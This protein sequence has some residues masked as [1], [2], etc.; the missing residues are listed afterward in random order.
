MGIQLTDKTY[1]LREV[2]KVVELDTDWHR[3]VPVAEVLKGALENT[4]INN[5]LVLAYTENEGVTAYSSF[6]HLAD[7]ILMIEHFKKK[8]LDGGFEIYEAVRKR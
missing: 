7:V 1:Q 2:E 6:G 4:D 5:V 3:D 8:L